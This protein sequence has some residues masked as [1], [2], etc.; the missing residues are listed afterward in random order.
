M[1]LIG[2]PVAKR[3]QNAGADTKQHHKPQSGRLFLPKAMAHPTLDRRFGSLSDIA[4][5]MRLPL[6]HA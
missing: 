6:G 2:T 3:P 4:L 1:K 5:W